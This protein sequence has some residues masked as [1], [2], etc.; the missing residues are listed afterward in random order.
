M[1]YGVLGAGF[2]GVAAAY[3]LAKFGNAEKV[4]LT[5]IN[6]ELA[7]NGAEKVNNLL[8][9]SIVEPIV[10]DVTNT[11][12][13]ENFLTPLNAVLSAVPYYLNPMIAKSSVATKTHFNDL[14]G[15]TPTVQKELELDQPAR[16]AGI[17][18]IPDCGV[19]P[20][21][22]S[23]L[24]SLAI[25]KMDSVDNVQIRCGGLPQNPKPPLNYQLLFCV[26]GLTNEYFNETYALRDSK[27]VQINAF[28]ELEELEF[29]EPVGKCEAF[30]TAGGT[31]TCPWTYE[32]KINTFEYKTV[33]YPG[34][35]E[36]IKLLHDLGLFDKEPIEVKGTTVSP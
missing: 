31:S 5:D 14:G 19:M 21:M 16:E 13:L 36:K 3:D 33:R 35:F 7:K 9:N 12:T 1:K 26:E 17:S 22:G 11:A 27:V 15:S 18:I 30:T 23:H 34:H 4:Y 6:F 32:G 8:G 10:I 29:P 20:G 25:S 2:Q 24:A 28:D